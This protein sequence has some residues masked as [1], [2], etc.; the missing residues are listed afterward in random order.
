MYRRQAP[1][2]RPGGAVHVSSWMES[3][4]LLPR[5]SLKTMDNQLKAKWT[6]A[7]VV[8]R[9]CCAASDPYLRTMP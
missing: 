4:G 7:V 6:P 3:Y 5:V 1:A 8:D 9:L 2:L